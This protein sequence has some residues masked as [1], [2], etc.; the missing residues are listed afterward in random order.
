[1][2]WFSRNNKTFKKHKVPDE[3]HEI[4]GFDLKHEFLGEKYCENSVLHI[5]KIS[6]LPPW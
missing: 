6:A 2:F 1:M 5:G 4:L 3:K